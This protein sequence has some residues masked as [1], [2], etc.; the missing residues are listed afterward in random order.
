MKAIFLLFLLFPLTL[1]SQLKLDGK[2]CD[3]KNGFCLSFINDSIFEI[4]SYYCSDMSC[5]SGSGNYK[6]NNNTLKLSIINY[7]DSI[8]K[9]Y[10]LNNINCNSQD[11]IILNF[12]LTDKESKESIPFGVILMTNTNGD[13][14]YTLTNI[15]GIGTIKTLKSNKEFLIKTSYVGYKSVN[16]KIRLDNCFNIKIDLFETCMGTYNKGEL[17]YKIIRLKP[18]KLIISIDNTIIKLKKLK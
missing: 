18:N 8:F 10:Q 5:C 1:F 9:S 4:F 13:T 2:Y 16:F 7:D 12:Y 11:S 14:L 3:N 15:D 6:I 17:S